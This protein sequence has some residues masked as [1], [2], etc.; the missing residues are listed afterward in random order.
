MF[1]VTVD[2]D[3]MV[4]DIVE[5]KGGTAISNNESAYMKCF[6]EVLVSVAIYVSVA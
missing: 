5:C 6:S 3:W 1:H 2:V 4:K